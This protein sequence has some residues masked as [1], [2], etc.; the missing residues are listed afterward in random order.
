MYRPEWLQEDRQR[1][2]DMDRWYKL[3]G[4]AKKTHKFHG[5]YTGL[6]EISKRLELEERIEK[7]YEA[8][9]KKIPLWVRR[10]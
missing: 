9:L 6:F 2:K 10:D 5:V 7:A 1:M 4:R 3:D 8:N